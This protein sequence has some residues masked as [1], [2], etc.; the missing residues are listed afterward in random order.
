MRSIESWL[1]VVK[2]VV[3]RTDVYRKKDTFC[4]HT[5]SQMIPFIDNSCLE[6][7]HWFGLIGLVHYRSSFLKMKMRLILRHHP[8]IPECM[9]LLHQLLLP[10][11][12]PNL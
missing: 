7:F 4:R 8:R 9:N 10:M 1:N 12:D 6:K 2:N 3:R 5:R 11:L